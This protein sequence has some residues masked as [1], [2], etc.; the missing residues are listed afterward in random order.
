MSCKTGSRELLKKLLRAGEI[1]QSLRCLPSHN[2][3]RFFIPSPPSRSLE[4]SQEW[5]QGTARSKPC[6]LPAVYNLSLVFYLC[7]R[8]SIAVSV[9]SQHFIVQACVNQKFAPSPPE[10]SLTLKFTNFR[11]KSFSSVKVGLAWTGAIFARI[12]AF[13]YV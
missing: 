13:P 5:S 4:H 9:H 3:H 11:S 7:S 6:E 2:Q 1:V 10:K 8:M 12:R